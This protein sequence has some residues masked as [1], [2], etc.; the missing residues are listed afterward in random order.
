MYD[1]AL[2]ELREL[3][4]IERLGHKEGPLIQAVAGMEGFFQVTG[5]ENNFRIR[6]GLAQPIGE[7]PSTHLRH[8]HIGQEKIDFFRVRS[9]DETLGVFPMGVDAGD[10]DNDG[11]EDLIISNLT[12]E[13]ATLYVNNGKG[14][15]E[16][17]S[18]E[19]SV[20]HSIATIHFERG[21]ASDAT[22]AAG[23]GAFIHFWRA[24]VVASSTDPSIVPGEKPAS[25]RR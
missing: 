3:F 18:F 6:A 19:L 22:F 13:Y 20:L 24:A 5:N 14:W 1:N 17:R 7:M 12:G 9:G 16:D 2:P 8:D 23:G 11:D 4:R 10:F 15:F 21:G 25:A